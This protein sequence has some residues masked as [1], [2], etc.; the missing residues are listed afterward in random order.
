M[1]TYTTGFITSGVFT[2][3]ELLSGAPIDRLAPPP[4]KTVADVLETVRTVATS[5]RRELT[6]KPRFE[7]GQAVT[8]VQ[9]ISADHTRL[10]R[11]ARGRTG[12]I[13][14]YRGAY[15][16]ADAYAKGI[17]KHEHHYT[18]AFTAQ[19]LWGENAS[20]HDTVRLDLWECYFVQT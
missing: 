12:K 4:A 20:E 16:L 14:A 19:E 11:Y 15:L 17:S 10:P 5:T 13:V 2:T 1:L 8:T 9:D 3:D 6:T 18:A 7:V